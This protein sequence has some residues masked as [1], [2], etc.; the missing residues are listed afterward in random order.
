LPKGH[1]Q[2]EEK[3]TLR[4]A[5]GGEQ[6]DQRKHGIAKQGGHAQTPKSPT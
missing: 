4:D 1:D 3:K 6:H 2:G 5:E